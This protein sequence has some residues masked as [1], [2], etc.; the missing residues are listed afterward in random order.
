[1]SQQ[2][3]NR[4]IAIP[5]MTMTELDISTGRP[6]ITI[7]AGDYQLRT[8]TPDD[9]SDRWAAWFADSHVAYMINAPNTRWDRE[10]VIKYINQFDQKSAL[11][12]GIFVRQSR[13]LIG[14]I[15]FDVNHATRKA[16]INALVGEAEYRNKGVMSEIRVPLYDYMFDTFRLKML[17]ASALARNHIVV[18]YMLRMGWK[19]D[20]T[21]PAHAKANSDNTM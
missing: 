15:T 11:L 18:G 12:F 5:N 17:L 10:A 20:Q 16:L 8:L 7:D 19:L 9:A 3:N 1:M 13:Q 14:I 6:S 21:L 2:R 4:S